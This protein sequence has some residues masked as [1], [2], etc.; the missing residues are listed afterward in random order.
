MLFNLP[1]WTVATVVFN[2]TTSLP[3][4][5]IQSLESTGALRSVVGEGKHSMEKLR[6]YFLVYAVV[7]NIF[8]FGTGKRAEQ[9]FSEDG[10]PYS[11]LRRLRER[12]LGMCRKGSVNSNVEEAHGEGEDPGENSEQSRRFVDF[13]NGSPSHPNG[14]D[15]DGETTPLLPENFIRWERSTKQRV[16]ERA[17]KLI[18]PLPEPVKKLL[19]VARSFVTPTAIGA[20]LG[21]IIGLVPALHR[22]FFSPLQEGGYF[23]AWLTIDL[24]NVGEL[25]VTLQVIVVGVELSLSLQS[26]KKGENSGDVPWGAAVYVIV[27]RFLVMPL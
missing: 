26:M 1:R 5:L 12:A 20:L 18:E 9:G 8:T 27:T 17:S 25:F 4:F 10:F 11:N 7:N 14:G 24:R 16:S 13:E 3:L 19:R 22:L 21:A 2:N 6:S 15:S 23:N